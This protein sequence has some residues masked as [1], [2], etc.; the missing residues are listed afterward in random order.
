MKDN[1]RLKYCLYARKSSESDE[2]QAISIDG[3]LKEMQL[4]AK[5]EK[6]DITETIYRESLSQR[7]GATTRIS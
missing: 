1:A 6:L 4:L 5:R 7:I 3:Q 2:R